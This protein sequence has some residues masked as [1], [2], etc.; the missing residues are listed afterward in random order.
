MDRK[1][2]LSDALVKSREALSRFPFMFPLESVIKQLEYLIEVDSGR[3]DGGDLKTI[4]IG[5]IAARDVD[6]LDE[7]LAVTLHEVSAE[8]RK[9]I[10]EK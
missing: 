9:M 8:V 10:T 3:A 4:N 7:S 1:D 2:L 6:E 5:E